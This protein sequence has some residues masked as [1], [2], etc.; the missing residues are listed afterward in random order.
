MIERKHEDECYT[1]IFSRWIPSLTLALCH[2]GT[3]VGTRTGI[4]AADFPVD[5][6]SFR[7]GSWKGFDIHPDAIMKC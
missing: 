1:Q 7:L 6:G 3:E 5:F 2:I 4:L